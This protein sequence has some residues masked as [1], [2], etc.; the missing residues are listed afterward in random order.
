[1]GS[2]AGTCKGLEAYQEQVGASS[3]RKVSLELLHYLTQWVGDI[4]VAITAEDKPAQ[5]KLV[6]QLRGISGLWAHAELNH[7]LDE[8]VN[9]APGY[10]D[11]VILGERIGDCIKEVNDEIERF[12][13]TS[14]ASPHD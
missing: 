4:Q 3:A 14:E 11:A 6:H 8:L 13:S 5:R 12:V 9:T 10:S 2:A 1:M 7:L